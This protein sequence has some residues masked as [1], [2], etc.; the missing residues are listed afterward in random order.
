MNEFYMNIREFQDETVVAICDSNLM[1]E[2]LKEG[3][4]K[5]EISNKFYGTKLFSLQECIQVL[6]NSVN[7]NL[8]GEKIITQALKMGLIHKDSILYINNVPHAMII[9]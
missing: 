9:F 8:V 3:R 6:K 4:F 5:L 1:G 7:A 2:V